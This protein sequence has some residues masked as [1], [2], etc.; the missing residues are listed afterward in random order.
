MGYRFWRR[1]RL[2]PGVTLN[3]GKS[4][5]SLSF[6]PRGAKLTVGPRG[7]RATVGIPGTGL[8]ATTTST[9]ASARG[10][11]RET[12]GAAPPEERLTLGFFRRL[13]TPPEERALVAGCR[14]LAHGSEEA[15]L[16]TLRDAVHLADGAYL[17]GF[18]ALRQGR[19][20]EAATFLRAAAEHHEQL[21]RCLARYGIAATWRLPITEEVCARI[22]PDRRGVL[23]GLVEVYQLQHRPAEAIACLERLRELSPEDR[24]VTLSLVELLLEAHPD[25]RDTARRVVELAE[26]VGNDTPIDA[27][28]LLYR[29]RALRILGLL[30]AARDALTV[31]LRR[32][33]GRPEDLLLALRYER[34]GVYEQ[35]GRKGR[36]RADLELLAAADPE[37]RDVAARLGLT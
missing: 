5:G 31:A 21:G 3:L 20:E 25:D 9:G 36:A 2:A 17:A 10:G 11:R 34:A 12:A 15:A 32:R 7:S 29:A 26:G 1:V 13:V 28:V 24:V 14:E 22:G 16:A 4:G 35:L 19:L 30:E 18:L 27:A 23:L 37:Y 8:F 33:K 6:G